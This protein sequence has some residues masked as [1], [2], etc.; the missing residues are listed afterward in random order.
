M[1]SSSSASSSLVVDVL[2]RLVVAVE[3][4]DPHDAVEVGEPLG[5]VGLV[6]VVHVDRLGEPLAGLVLATG[7]EQRVGVRELQ[8]CRPRLG[9]RRLE[10]RALQRHD[11]GVELAEVASSAGRHDAHLDAAGPV[12]PVDLVGAGHR[13]GPLRAAEAALAV[14]HDRPVAVRAGDTTGGA[15]L[16]ERVGVL[17]GRVRRDAGSLTHDGETPATGDGRL[18]VL[19]R[20]VGPVLEQA[21]RHHQVARHDLG[22]L[23]RQRAQVAAD[24]LVEL[25]PGHVRR[26]RRT[27]RAGRAHVAIA[28]VV[29]VA[30][31]TAAVGA[32]VV[33]PP[34]P[35]EGRP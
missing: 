14:G 17:P 19:P 25:L 32:V 8:S 15:E 35:P 26:D 33:G 21:R 30:P 27:G 5:R 1:S 28:P 7:G 13:D 18:R 12:E 29:V 11:G 34:C 31:T 20:Q 24:R 6:G 16:R 3:G 23:E 2:D 4:V 9:A 10:L 22:R